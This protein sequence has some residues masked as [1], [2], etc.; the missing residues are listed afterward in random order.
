MSTKK[1]RK[2]L[3]DSLANEFVFGSQKQ[4]EVNTD[5]DLEVERSHDTPNSQEKLIEP[6]LV[7]K[8]QTPSKEATVRFTVDMPESMHRKLSMLAAKTG[9]KKVDIVR[10]LLEEALKD[11]EE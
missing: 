1:P 9:R 10:L 4:A 11:V 5:L 7:S 6:G 2:S 8:L 3:E